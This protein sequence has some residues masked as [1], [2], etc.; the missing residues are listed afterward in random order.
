M[1]I[2]I[3]TYHRSHNYGALLQAIALRKV[4][5][6]MGHEVTFIDY[7]PA[8][9][10]HMY[11][12]FSFHWL[13]SRKGVKGKCKYVRDVILYYSYRKKRKEIFEGFIAKYIEPYTSSTNENYDVIVHGSDQIWRKQP[14]IKKYN[15]VYFGNHLIRAKRKI[16]YA[17]SMG[18]LPRKESDKAIL[19]E[20]ISYLDNISV[21]EES[22]QVLVREMGFSGVSHDID[23]TLLLPMDYWINK[24]NLKRVKERYALYYK[25]Q[26]SFDMKI[27]RGYVESKGLKLKVIHSKANCAD[28][29][30]NFTTA[31]PLEFLQM[32]YGADMVF[33]S[34]FHG[35]AFALIFHKPF[36]ASF[37]KN[38]DRASSLLRQCDLE[39]RLVSP[40]AS[41]PS[42]EKTIDFSKVD[43]VLEGLR[44][45]SMAYFE[46]SLFHKYQK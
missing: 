24:F 1:K 25:I 8:Y 18:I 12:L 44:E 4:L 42:V 29:E 37:Q 17:A 39:C 32:L 27:L 28:S 3:L 19:K 7:W 33:T 31:G 30:E 16:T 45:T 46:E 2:G 23:P 11:A 13:M 15:P 38:G 21:R 22:L 14:E 43:S 35:L 36:F 26:D 10:R 40:Y 34:S 41:I 9:H 5:A 20:Y 6:D